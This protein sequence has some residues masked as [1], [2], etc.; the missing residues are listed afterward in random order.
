[1]FHY[2]SPGF[3]AAVALVSYGG[4]SNMGIQYD[5]IKNY[6]PV[7]FFRSAATIGAILMAYY[8]DRY[9]GSRVSI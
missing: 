1:M 5:Q 6:L 2:I 7:Y 4:G 9:P 8:A 3:G